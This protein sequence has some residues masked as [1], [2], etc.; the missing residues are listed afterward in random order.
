M[1]NKAMHKTK[2]TQSMKAKHTSNAN[3][4][5]R[6]GER[7]KSNKITW[8]PFPSTPWRNLSFDQTFEP[9]VRGKS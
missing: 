2:L 3:T 6:R 5:T 7:E 4:K 8:S 1:L 9:T